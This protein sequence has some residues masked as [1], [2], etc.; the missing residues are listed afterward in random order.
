[1]LEVDLDLCIGCKICERV[2]PFGTIVVVPETK[3]AKVL[4]GCT[5]CGTCVNACPENAL[6][7][8]RKAISEEEIAQFKN[9]FIWG[10]WERKGGEIKI[11]NVVLEL[12]GKGKDV[13]NKLGESLAVILPGK[14]VKHLIPEL[15]HHG[16]DTVYLCEHELLDHYS[17][18]GFTNVIA[19]IISTEKPSVVLYGATPNGRDLAP[20]IA[21]RLALGLTADCTGLDINSSRQLVQTR[22]AFGG[23][24]MASILSPYT[25]PQ[26]S[27]VR[28]GVFPKPKPDTSKTGKTQEVE[29]NL[30][31]I[32]IRTKIIEEIPSEDEG[33]NIEE[34]NILVSAGR[35]IGSKEN[36]EM[37][38][39]MAKVINGTVSGSRALVDLGWIPHP[40]QVG[41]SGKTVAPTLYFALGI[42][43]AIQHLVGMT[44]SDAVVAINKDPNAT[45]FDVA[46]FGIVGDIMEIIPEFIRIVKEEKEKVL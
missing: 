25:R 17:T 37:I 32:S 46:D 8:E 28:P 39:E 13:A 29:V 24:I 31:P 21:G 1:M 45:I 43:G 35:G 30:K 11:K 36:L 33:I 27:T 22:P 6:S 9:V 16:A 4:D 40:Q 5:L 2:C 26:M 7:I 41:Q 15:F 44:S 12:L 38:Q 20:R 19:S 10:E 42:S 3:K 34:A 18:D 14:D 23:N